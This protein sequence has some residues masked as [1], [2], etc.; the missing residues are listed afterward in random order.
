MIVERWVYRCAPGKLPTL[1]KRFEDH[2]IKLFA[3]H[4]YKP[5]GFYTTMVGESHQELT[6]F[7]EWD[8]L[9]H[10]EKSMS[11]FTQDP[12]WLSARAES[13]KDGPL[14]LNRSNELL[15]PVPFFK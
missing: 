1:L 7:L 6:Y 14:L 3:R 8:S 4:A 5:M 13:E 2:T 11:A 15:T 12:E 10:R 9:D